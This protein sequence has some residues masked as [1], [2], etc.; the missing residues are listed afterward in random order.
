MI[1]LHSWNGM[2]PKKL[3]EGFLIIKK[4]SSFGDLRADF[5]KV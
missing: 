3:S 2:L 4:M 1:S 5:K